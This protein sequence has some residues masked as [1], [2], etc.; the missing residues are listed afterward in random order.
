MGEVRPA[1]LRQNFFST[2]DG[3]WMRVDTKR[4]SHL[5]L[6]LSS[7][8][9][10]IERYFVPHDTAIDSAASTSSM[11]LSRRPAARF[12]S[13]FYRWSCY[14]RKILYRSLMDHQ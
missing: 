14:T 12:F 8:L 11:A 13:A 2:G 7:L 10:S 6:R 1:D 5:L 9:D 3:K 4:Q